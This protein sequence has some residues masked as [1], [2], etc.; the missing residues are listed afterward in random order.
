MI[1]LDDETV[2]QIGHA[3]DRCRKDEYGTGP[4]WSEVVVETDH[5]EYRVRVTQL[6][7]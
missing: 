1:A 3:F 7:S 2:R 4:M 5:G 6:A